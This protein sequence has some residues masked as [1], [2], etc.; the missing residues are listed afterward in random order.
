VL[1]AGAARAT[2]SGG[3]GLDPVRSPVLRIRMRSAFD[4]A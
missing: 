3:F 2:A 1:K 4:R